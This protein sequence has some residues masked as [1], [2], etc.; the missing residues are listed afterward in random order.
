MNISRRKLR[1]IVV[2]IR[3]RETGVFNRVMFPESRK[4][5][6]SVR[7]DRNTQQRLKF[8]KTYHDKLHIKGE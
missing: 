3:T 5:P 8:W 1:K 2:E 7:Q 6:L 4:I